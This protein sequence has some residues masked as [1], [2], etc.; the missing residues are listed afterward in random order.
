MKPPRPAKAERGVKTL[1]AVAYPTGA[2]KLR[3]TGPT[4]SKLC[5]HKLLGRFYLRCRRLAESERRLALQ[6]A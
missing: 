3:W 1:F 4:S 6:F 2:W 5:R